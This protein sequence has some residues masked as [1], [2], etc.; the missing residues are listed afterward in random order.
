MALKLTVLS[1]Q[2]EQLGALGSIV[3]GVGGGGIGRAND[4][5]WV[6]PDPMR[7]LSAHH[8]RIQFKNGLYLLLDTSTNGV[9]VNGHRSTRETLNDG[10]LVMIG[11]ARFRFAIRPALNRNPDHSA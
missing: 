10:D 9:Y 8:A 2:S 5:D 6:L 7:Y 1:E 11:K 4:N 3:I